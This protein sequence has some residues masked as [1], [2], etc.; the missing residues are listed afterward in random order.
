MIAADFD[1]MKWQINSLSEKE[2]ALEKFP[3]LNNRFLEFAKVKT[4]SLSNDQIVR[5]IVYCYHRKSPFVEHY[6]NVLER[7]TMILDFMKIKPGADGKYQVDIQDIV[8]SKDENV[9]RMI[10]QFC[11]FENSMAWMALVQTQE[12]Y[13]NLFDQM[14]A[15]SSKEAKEVSDVIIKMEQIEKRIDNLSSKLFQQDKYQSDFVAS[16]QLEESR[17]RKLVPEHYAE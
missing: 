12:A 8:R 11:K 17:K 2:S 15:S 5:Y 1:K 14:E 3:E 7:K 9:G 4:I 10:L 6:E 16:A 13:L